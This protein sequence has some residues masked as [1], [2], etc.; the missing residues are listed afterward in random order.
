M[1]NVTFA[2]QLSACGCVYED[3]MNL[4]INLKA[5]RISPPTMTQ[6]LMKVSL[7]PSYTN[8]FNYRVCI[9]CAACQPRIPNHC[10]S[11]SQLFLNLSSFI[12][13]ILDKCCDMPIEDGARLLL[14]IPACLWLLRHQ[15]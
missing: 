7:T 3:L 5:V 2:I 6:L 8:T 15:Q 11:R 1:I 9:K 14:K 13:L 10:V 4:G 12:A